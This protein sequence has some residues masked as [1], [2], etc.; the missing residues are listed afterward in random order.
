MGFDIIS[1]FLGG[2]K[3]RKRK[4][5]AVVVMAGRVMSKHYTLAAAKK[6]S[7]SIR[8]SRVRP[9]KV[10]RFQKLR[11]YSKRV[12]SYR[13]S[14]RSVRAFRKRNGITG[15]MPRRRRRYKY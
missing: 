7:K 14:K 2:T 5:K 1:S 4:F 12:V 6:K 13:K 8:G 10:G 3:K 9:Y 15:R 11:S